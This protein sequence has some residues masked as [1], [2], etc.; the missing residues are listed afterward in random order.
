MQDE[1][2]A[3]QPDYSL[4][5]DALAAYDCLDLIEAQALVGLL[6]YRAVA[7]AGLAYSRGIYHQLAQLLMAG[8][9]LV[10]QEEKTVVYII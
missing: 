5:G 8:P 7:A 4:A 10:V 3:L 1:F 6:P 2:S 9:Q